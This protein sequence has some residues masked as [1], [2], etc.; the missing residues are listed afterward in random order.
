VRV[1][2]VV[3][4]VAGS[5]ALRD[6]PEPPAADGALLVET[7]AVGVCGTDRDILGGAYGEAPAG[8]PFL[9]LGHES[10]GRVLEAPA[11]SGF[12]AGDRVVGI[13]RRPDPV[14]CAACAA[15]E[16]DMCRNG[17]YTERG[18]KG[19]H[20]FAA[21]RFR[22]EPEFAVGVDAALGDAAVLLEP[23]SI[24]AKAWDHVERIG[25]RAVWAPRNVVVTGAGPVGLLAALMAVQ[26]G[27][28]VHVLD[29]VTRG[30]KP[31]LVRALGATYHAGGGIA[32]AG[33]GIDVVLECTGA[34]ELVTEAFCRTGPSGIVCLA[35]LSSG[36]RR[37]TL[38][39]ARLNQEMVLEND[40]VVGV[41]N[42]NRRHYGA[43][44]RALA[45]APR[46]WL[47]RLLTQRV[48][49]VE[50]KRAFEA[51]GEE[52]VKAVLVP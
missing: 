23:A 18:I 19:R 34:P 20:G 1:L 12:R 22:L 40:V 14:P 47:D 52:R 42:A 48:P 2:T 31:D 38:D 6:V 29:R 15:G 8:D 44:R 43:A 9:V 21:E 10:L 51:S 17:R 13:V 39:V 30:P 24:V 4:G 46:G 33:D 5:G 28:D 49:L 16:W 36:A 27:L 37:V 7:L 35:G 26:R 11:G 41:V 50:W 32:A 45:E 3:P 25:M